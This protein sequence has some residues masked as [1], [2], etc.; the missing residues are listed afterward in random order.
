MKTNKTSPTGNTCTK[1]KHEQS[2]WALDLCCS[3][4]V[5]LW[6]ESWDPI[7]LHIFNS[8]SPKAN[9]CFSIILRCEHQTVQNNE[10]KLDN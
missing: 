2:Y 6:L 10:L 3:I 7:V 1:I 8:Y 9:N 4:P 5:R